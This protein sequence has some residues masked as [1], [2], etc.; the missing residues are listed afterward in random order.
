MQYRNVWSRGAWFHRTLVA[1]SKDSRRYRSKCSIG[2]GS[3]DTVQQT[4][5]RRLSLS[6]CCSP[7]FMYLN[8]WIV[9]SRR[10]TGD[11]L[12]H[13]RFPIWIDRSLVSLDENSQR[14]AAVTAIDTATAIV[15]GMA[16]TMAMA[17]AT[18]MV[19]SRQSGDRIG[20]NQSTSD[21]STFCRRQTPIH[22]KAVAN[23]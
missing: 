20:L 10:N 23:G 9:M 15:M 22:S 14:I 11:S 13:F 16:M 2:F 12:L 19:S 8:I 17:M 18:E 6:F 4:G 7:R 3:L 5:R 1:V 21:L